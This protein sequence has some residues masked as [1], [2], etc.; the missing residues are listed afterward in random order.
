MMH[1]A[2]KYPVALAAALALFATSA[3]AQRSNPERNVYFGDTHAHSELSSDAYGFG[4]RL[5]PETAYRLDGARRSISRR[6]QDQ[7]RGPA[8]LLHDDRSLGVDWD[9]HSGHGQVSAFYNSELAGWFRSGTKAE[10][11]RRPTLVTVPANRIRTR[12]SNAST[13][14]TL[15]FS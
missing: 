15:D 8:R 13:R 1:S 6:L 4:N 9:G 11:E 5:P 7:A 2:M 3:H 14:P 10:R 12:L